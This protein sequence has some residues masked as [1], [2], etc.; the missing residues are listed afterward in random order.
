[1]WVQSACSHAA[2]SRAGKAAAALTGGQAVPLQPLQALQDRWAGQGAGPAGHTGEAASSN[3]SNSTL[4][5]GHF[6]KGGSW[7]S[8]R[9]CSGIPCRSWRTPCPRPGG[10]WWGNAGSEPPTEAPAPCPGRPCH[11]VLLCFWTSMGA[12]AAQEWGVPCAP[13]SE[14]HFPRSVRGH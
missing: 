2:L 4:S 13:S 7:V 10:R 14:K 5:P 1:M 12:S 8:H 3:S 6:S 9:R 11:Q